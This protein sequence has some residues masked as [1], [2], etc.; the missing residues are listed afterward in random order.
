MKP[1]NISIPK[2]TRDFDPLTMAKRNWIIDTIRS[3]FLLFGFKELQTPAMENLSVLL[4]KYGEEGDK[5]IFKILNSGLYLPRA[6]ENEIDLEKIGKGEKELTREISEKALRY[7]LTVPFARFVAKNHK[8]LSFPFKRFQ[9]QPVWRAD[10]PQKGRFREFFQCDADTVGSSSIQTDAE[11]ALLAYEVIKALGLSGFQMNINHRGFLND[12]CEDYCQGIEVEK[13]LP[14]LDKQD[15]IGTEKTLALLSDIGVEK[16][17]IEGFEKLF[18]I[19]GDPESVISSLHKLL[20]R[21]GSN[22]LEALRS[23]VEHLERPVKDGFLKINPG[24][25]R[26]LDYYTG[27]IFEIISP[28]AGIGSISGGGRYDNLTEIFGVPGIPGVGLS[29]GLDRIMEVMEKESLFPELEEQNQG[30]LICP[31]DEAST[32]VGWELLTSL[33]SNGSK[34]WMYP[35]IQKLK[36]QIQYADK[37]NFDHVIIIGEAEIQGGKFLLRDLKSGEQVQLPK[38]ELLKRLDPNG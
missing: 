26:G 20:A 5:L 19:S 16:R 31:M 29:F 15:K 21:E 25:A 35:E 9:I 18:G 33:R 23:M 7:D 28:K 22:G 17:G 32:H 3:K 30:F 6:G 38:E 4:G 2:G 13:I 14:I 27:S 10:R 12:F 8:E 34:G 1:E 11:M 24:L 37:N 36:K